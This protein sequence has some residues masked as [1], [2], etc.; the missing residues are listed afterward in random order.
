[1]SNAWLWNVTP[2]CQSGDNLL[3]VEAAVF[4]ENFAGMVSADHHSG[5]EN[6]GDIAL[7]G[8][9]VHGGL[10]RFRIERDSQ[11]AQKLEIRMVSRQRK[12]LIRGQ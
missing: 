7:M 3:A 6:S 4:N 2:A 1:M 9:R 5:D 8:L 11:R 10:V 12:N